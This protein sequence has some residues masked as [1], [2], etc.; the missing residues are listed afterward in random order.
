LLFGN[1]KR[2]EKFLVSTLFPDSLST[3][4]A[5]FFVNVLHSGISENAQGH[6]SVSMKVT[7]LQDEILRI[8]SAQML[9][10]VQT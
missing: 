2:F 3:K 7:S 4:S 6:P 9:V 5:E 10:P 1:Y 8:L